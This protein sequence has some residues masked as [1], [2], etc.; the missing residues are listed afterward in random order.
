MQ[1]QMRQGNV[2]SWVRVPSN[3]SECPKLSTQSAHFSS[4][5]ICRPQ[6]YLARIL[7]TVALKNSKVLRIRSSA[8]FAKISRWPTD[9]NVRYDKWS[10]TSNIQCWR[11]SERPS[12]HALCW[13]KIRSSSEMIGLAMLRRP[14]KRSCLP[15]STKMPSCTNNLQMKTTSKLRR[16]RVSPTIHGNHFCKPHKIR[17]QTPVPSMKMARRVIVALS[18]ALNLAVVIRAEKT[19]IGI[20]RKPYHQPKREWQ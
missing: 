5:L 13:K 11:K 12:S 14:M 20:R 18:P 10:R 19:R 3:D 9:R 16:Q 6:T 15:R 1:C 4:H 2:Q 8:R 17:G 7:L